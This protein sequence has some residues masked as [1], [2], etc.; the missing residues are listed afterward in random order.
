MAVD[1][2]SDVDRRLAELMIQCRNDPLLFVKTVFPW[3]QPGT[4]LSHVTEMQKWQE[5]YLIKLRDMLVK[6]P[7]DGKNP[8]LCRQIAVASGHGVGKSALSC[9]LILWIMSTR[10]DSKGT[11]TANSAKQLK[12]K[13]WGELSKWLNMC[14]TREW[15]EYHNAPQNM[16]LCHV[17]NPNEWRCDAIT[18]KEEN[19]EAFAGQHAH[20]SSSWYLFDEA[21]AIPSVIWKV[22]EG[23]K[24]GGEPFHF[25]FGNP[26]RKDGMFFDC[27]H[28][29]KSSWETIHVDSRDSTLLNNEQIEVF[30]K[31]CSTEDEKRFR[32]YGKFPETS[33][34]QFI[35]TNVIED[36]KNRIPSVLDGEPLICGIDVARGGDDF[37][38]IQFRRGNDARTFKKYKI[39][40]RLISD[41]TVFIDLID[42]AC[43][44]NPPDMMYI[45]ETGM[46]GPI[47]DEL[48]KM[49]LSLQG[50]TFW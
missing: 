30:L 10:P 42:K 26:T 3:G 12:T 4:S 36:S 50:Y 39:P 48:V 35:A 7:F 44:D 17:S 2:K 5:D 47:K 33:E 40:G 46:G 43:T 15:F 41:S 31:T 22:T 13:T 14:V 21:S 1:L 27:F 23:G 28:D 49:G 18:C 20:G 45:D 29:N 24:F 11:I 37:G 34:D 6:E 25:V 38:V 16:S 32:V 19:S 9:W 8:V